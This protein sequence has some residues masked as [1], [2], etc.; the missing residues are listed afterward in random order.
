MLG[1]PLPITDPADRL[2]LVLVLFTTL[3]ATIDDVDGGAKAIADAGRY[4]ALGGHPGAVNHMQHGGLGRLGGEEKPDGG[5]QVQPGV[6]HQPRVVEQHRGIA[7][8]HRLG[9]G[10]VIEVIRELLCAATEIA[11][12]RTAGPLLVLPVILP[13]PSG[14]TRLPL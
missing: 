12:P 9:E 8:K 6:G 14:V 2:P 3:Y 1:Q 4:L 5:C 7:V 10:A 11:L 13:A